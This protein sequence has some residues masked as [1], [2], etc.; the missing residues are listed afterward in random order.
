[1]RRRH[2]SPK[3]VQLDPEV[4]SC[5]G[6]PVVGRCARLPLDESSTNSRFA[7]PSETGCRH[8]LTLQPTLGEALHAKGY[9]YYACL[10]DYDTVVRDFEQARPF[11]PNFSLNPASL[12]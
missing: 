8:C 2:I 4:R 3:Q 10:K 9:Y 12:A 6:L 5:L 1:L 11:L 7:K